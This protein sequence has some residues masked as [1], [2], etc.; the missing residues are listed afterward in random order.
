M[1]SATLPGLPVEMI[2]EVCGHLEFQDQGTLRRVNRFFCAIASSHT[3]KRIKFCMCKRDLDMLRQITNNPLYASY[4]QDLIYVVETLSLEP[5]TFE[6]YARAIEHDEM[7]KRHIGDYIPRVRA[8]SPPRTYLPSEIREL[9]RRYTQFFEQQQDILHNRRDFEVIKEVIAKLPNLKEISVSSDGEIAKVKKSPFVDCKKVCDG[10]FVSD[11]IS[12]R[13]LEVMLKGVKAAGT[14]L[15]TMRVSS[16]Y[17]TCLDPATFGLHS[18]ADQLRNMTHFDLAIQAVEESHMP[19]P[20]A[21]GRDDPFDIS[22]Q[23]SECNK[24]MQAGGLRR[25]LESMPNLIFLKLTFIEFHSAIPGTF[26]APATLQHIMP[27]DAHWPK[28]KCLG[29][30]NIMTERQ[31]IVKLLARHKDT[32]FSFRLDQMRLSSTSWI[33]TLPMLRKLFAGARMAALVTDFIISVSE[34]G[35]KKPEAWQLGNPEYDSEVN[36]L[37]VAVSRYITSKKKQECPLTEDNM[38]EFEEWDEDD[39]VDV[40]GSV[41]FDDWM[42][43]DE[44]WGD[45]EDEPDDDDDLPDLIPID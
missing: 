38:W 39:E 8:G 10:R 25:V 12:T 19:M 30:S 35:D 34:D 28:L 45:W 5:Q 14:Q 16:V 9:H 13:H 20:L 6:M 43:E 21:L 32:L 1:A 29:L 15:Q 44:L 24:T 42:D 33:V 23:L 37:G 27:Q 26:N 17:H 31:Y 36:E 18:I 2:H 4:I 22:N 7:I 40:F 3:L 41:L 11:R